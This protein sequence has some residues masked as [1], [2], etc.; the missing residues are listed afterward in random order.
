MALVAVGSDGN[1]SG[2]KVG[3]VYHGKVL[4]VYNFGVFCEFQDKYLKI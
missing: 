2:V 1:D 3:T 4:R